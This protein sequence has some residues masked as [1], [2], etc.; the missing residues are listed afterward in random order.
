M[1]ELIAWLETDRSLTPTELRI[2]EVFATHFGR[3][4][5]QIALMHA[6]SPYTPPEL[7]RADRHTLRVHLMRIRHKLSD[8]PW[9]IETMYGHGYY[10]LA[11]RTPEPLVHA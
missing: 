10:R 4:T 3:W 5:A 11:E 6:V 2:L 7:R 8:T 1:S 9:R